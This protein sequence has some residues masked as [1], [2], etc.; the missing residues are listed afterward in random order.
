M[1]CP[2]IRHSTPIRTS[3]Y[4]SQSHQYC[5]CHGWFC[6]FWFV[7]PCSRH[8]GPTAC[9]ISV[10]VSPACSPQLQ[11]S[12]KSSY[13]LSRPRVL[14]LCI[15]FR[16]PSP[17]YSVLSHIPAAFTCVYLLNSSPSHPCSFTALLQHLITILPCSSLPSLHPFLPLSLV[18]HDVLSFLQCHHSS[19]CFQFRLRFRSCWA[20][21]SATKTAIL[22]TGGMSVLEEWDELRVGC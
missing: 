5:H 7:S 1:Q 21:F 18:P 13:A 20:W 3:H 14:K 8:I 19:W 16:T 6:C 9:P 17:H 4:A 15:A 10:I 12:N 2:A 11:L 22:I